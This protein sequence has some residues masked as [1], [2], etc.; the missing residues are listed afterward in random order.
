[1]QK[2]VSFTDTFWHEIKKFI[3]QLSVSANDK[4]NYEIAHGCLLTLDSL[5]KESS[6]TSYK[7]KEIIVQIESKGFTVVLC[8]KT[9]S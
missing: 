5:S 9:D 8:I 2:Y 3:W 4:S 6:F 7:F 1:M